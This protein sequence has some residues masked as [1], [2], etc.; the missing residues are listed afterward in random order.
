MYVILHSIIIRWITITHLWLII[1]LWLGDHLDIWLL[2]QR[3]FRSLGTNS[4]VTVWWSMHLHWFQVL[5]IQ[6]QCLVTFTTIWLFAPDPAEGVTALPRPYSWWVWGWLPPPQNST[7][8]LGLRHRFRPFVPRAVPLSDRFRCI[9]IRY[10]VNCWF[11][12]GV[13]L[14][15]SLRKT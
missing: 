7:P 14:W 2:L 15:E 10:Q 6:I 5:T 3:C 4:G 9:C 8:A 11:V 13:V 1:V 12:D